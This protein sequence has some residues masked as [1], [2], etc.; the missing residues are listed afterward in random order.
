MHDR[1][2]HMKTS[3]TAV[4]TLLCLAAAGCGG[5]DG[6]TGAAPSGPATT[7]QAPTT[8]AATQSGPPVALSGTVTD[9]GTKDLAGDDEIRFDLG[10]SFFSPTYVKATPGSTVKV[11]LKN[12]GAMPH[13]FTVDA[14][15]VD[16]Q[17][18]PGEDT[19]VSVTIPA[20]GTLAFYCKF[21]KTLGMQGAF[22][23]TAGASAPAGSAS[24]SASGSDGA[25]GS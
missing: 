6:D 15:K 11:E 9:K 20:S 7:S 8:A 2:V 21:H 18:A 19:S 13:T 16:K 22:Y 1:E 17:V 23:G 12:G 4:T 10:D 14:P 3:L 24:S 25:Y 5:G